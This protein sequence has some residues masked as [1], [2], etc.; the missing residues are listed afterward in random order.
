VV[1]LCP[2]VPTSE[3]VAAYAGAGATWLMVTGWLDSLGALIAGGPPN[4]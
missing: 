2:A 4:D 1:V 3:E